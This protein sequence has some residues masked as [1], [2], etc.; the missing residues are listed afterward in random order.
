MSG[1]PIRLDVSTSPHDHDKEF[2]NLRQPAIVGEFSLNSD[3]DFVPD[4]SG[5]GYIARPRDPDRVQLDLNHGLDRV[6]RK[7]EAAQGGAEG[8]TNML[9]SILHYRQRFALASGELDSLHTDLVCYRGLLTTLLCSPYEGKE[10]WEVTAAKWRG[11]LYLRQQETEERRRQRERETERQKTMSSWGYK[12][13]Q[14]LTSTTPKASPDTSVP[15]NENEEFCCL[16]RSKVGGLSLVYG[17][18]MDAY[19]SQE[20]VQ[21]GD[22]LKP[23]KFVEMKTSRIVENERQDRTFRRFKILKWW[24]QSFLVG[25]QEVLCGWRDDNGMVWNLESFKVRELPKLGVEWKPNVCFNF[26]A[27]LLARLV[28]CVDE[29]LDS[30]AEVKF[31]PRRATI[32]VSVRKLDNREEHPVLPKWYTSQLFQ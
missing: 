24:A 22:R 16:F 30:V 27:V 20:E 14:Y 32:E 8:L 19:E 7:G 13:E 17:A 31:D 23:E 21:S 10:G 29:G 2:P 11:T 4:R 18:E 1:R 3:R 9:Q 5:L 28:H 25:T 6:I 15:V 26:L 12:F